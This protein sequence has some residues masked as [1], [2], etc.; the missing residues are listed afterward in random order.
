[1]I[2]RLEA[3]AET[4]ARALEEA[5]PLGC[6]V[7]GDAAGRVGTR[8]NA[9]LA[10]DTHQTAHARRLSRPGSGHVPATRPR[11]VRL[12]AAPGDVISREEEDR[13]RA[14]AAAPK[15][16]RLWGTPFAEVG[17]VRLNSAVYAGLTTPA[18]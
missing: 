16:V 8:N 12:S 5:S 2:E 4:T 13:V 18:A 9:L 7:S 10:D 3:A 17:A 14:L 15:R 11:R 6:G 1:M